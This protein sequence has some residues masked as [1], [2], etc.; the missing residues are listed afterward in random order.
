MVKSHLKIS[1]I[2]WRKKRFYHVAEEKI[3][4]GSGEELQQQNTDAGDQQ[5]IVPGRTD[6]RTHA[7]P[8]PGGIV[9]GH[10]GHHTLTNAD[11]HGIGNALDLHH[12]AE[13]SQHQIV[14]GGSQHVDADAGHIEEPREHRRGHA[15][16]VESPAVFPLNAPGQPQTQGQR[17]GGRGP[18]E[19]QQQ[20]AAGK[21]VGNQGRQSRPLQI[22]HCTERRFGPQGYDLNDVKLKNAFAFFLT[23]CY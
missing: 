18:V 10:N 13:G 6:R 20:I 1:L 21:D 19:G 5:A 4:H 14:V 9:V 15:H 17:R 3:G 2:S 7:Q 12:N 16:G 23:L 11:V 8:V 22:P